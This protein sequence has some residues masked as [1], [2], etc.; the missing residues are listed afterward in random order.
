[1]NVLYILIPIVIISLGAL[2][3]IRPKL[4]VLNKKHT[5]YIK[6]NKPGFNWNNPVNEKSNVNFEMHPPIVQSGKI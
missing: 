3:L 4:R 1:M 5:R 6:P 2:I